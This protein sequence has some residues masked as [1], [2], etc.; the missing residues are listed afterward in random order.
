MK[1]ALIALILALGLC[2]ANAGLVQAG[3]GQVILV[4]SQSK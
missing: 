1:Q 4:S 2:F 3:P